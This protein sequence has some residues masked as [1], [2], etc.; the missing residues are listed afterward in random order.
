MSKDRKDG[1]Y[2]KPVDSVHAIFP[3]LVNKRTDA[4]VCLKADFDVT[5][6]KKYIDKKNENSANKITLFH[7]FV[8]GVAKTVYHRPLLNRFISGKRYYDR[9]EIT[10]SFIAK[11][12]LSDKGEERL[13]ILKVDKNMN[14]EKISSK[15][16]NDVSKVR[17]A[18]KN[19]MDDTLKFITKF[20]RWL[21]N[22]IVSTIKWLDYHGWVPNSLCANDT[23]YSTVLLS[24]LGSIKANSCYHHLN[25]Y[26]T[27]SIV[28]TIGVIHPV[29]S[30]DSE[31]KI[32]EKQ[33]VDISFTLDERIADGFYFAKSVKLLEY[34]INNPE[35]LDEE[36]SKEFDYES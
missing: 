11:D 32:S 25:N 10:I 14:L 24:N 13:I 33:I 15:I 27:N 3:F 8:T 9:N 2:I 20:P 23:N 12:K 5:N 31:G 21:T 36:I 26:G 30:M 17:K 7:A 18:G 34:I 16:Y 29:Y 22:I 35:L 1:K 4:E 19:N 28:G 6:L